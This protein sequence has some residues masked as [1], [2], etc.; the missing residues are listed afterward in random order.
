MRTRSLIAQLWGQSKLVQEFDLFEEQLV[1]KT[2]T[3]QNW[4]EPA[5]I[6]SS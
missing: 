3:V 6:L 4:S 1:G 5:D 2:T